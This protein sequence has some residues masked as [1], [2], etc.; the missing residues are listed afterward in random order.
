MHNA[1]KLHPHAFIICIA[2][3]RSCYIAR[4]HL[5]QPSE[6]CKPAQHPSLAGHITRLRYL[7]LCRLCATSRWIG[8]DGWMEGRELNKLAATNVTPLRGANFA[9]LRGR[10]I[11][12]SVHY[13]LPSKFVNFIV[14][15]EQNL[16]VFLSLQ[17][18]HLT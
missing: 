14:R 8:M 17:S 4:L 11:S 1:A 15:T 7:L 18:C 16:I 13:K 12:P 3:Y 10:W 9:H 6:L 5:N 2:L